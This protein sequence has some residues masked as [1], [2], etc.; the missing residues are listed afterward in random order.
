MN[1]L[2]KK[3]RK[4]LEKFSTVFM[5]LGLVLTLFTVYVVLEFETVEKKNLVEDYDPGE[6][7]YVINETPPMAFIKDIPKPK[8]DEP[9]KPKT[10][11]ILNVID[12][13]D[14]THIENVIDKPT[15]IVDTPILNPDDI[16]EVVID[17]PIE[18]EIPFIR[19]E[20]APIYR[21]CEGLSEVENKKCFVRKISKHVQ[22]HFNSGLGQDLGLSSGKQKMYALFVIDKIGNVTQVKIKAPHK[23]LEKEVQRIVDKIPQF[24]PGKQR[25]NAVKVKYTLPI[26][27]HVE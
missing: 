7:T 12:K 26:T 17:D 22:K 11:A 14:E 25:G 3:P 8:F 4:Q 1:N 5:Q 2:K 24:T 16:V 15:D 18:D 27:F 19:I 23:R 13:V 21:G 10:T 6:N 9:V 20:E